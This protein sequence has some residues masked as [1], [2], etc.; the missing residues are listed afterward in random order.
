MA[1]RAACFPAVNQKRTLLE[2]AL[3]IKVNLP[4]EKRFFFTHCVLVLTVTFSL[5]LILVSVRLLNSLWLS[6][7]LGIYKINNIIT[8][9][10]NVTTTCLDNRT[11]AQEVKTTSDIVNGLSRDRVVD[12]I[13]VFVF[14]TDSWVLLHMNF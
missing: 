2:N 10:L 7:K 1:K 8:L 4:F 11:M 13:V 12:Y 9:N 14:L 6:T 3:N 5:R